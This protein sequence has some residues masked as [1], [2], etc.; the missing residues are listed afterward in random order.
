MKCITVVA[1]CVQY[2]FLNSL[3]LAHF[4]SPFHENIIF[5]AYISYKNL[6]FDKV[7]TFVLAYSSKHA[8]HVIKISLLLFVNFIIKHK[9]KNNHLTLI[10]MEA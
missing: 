10:L 2:S 6:A 9:E 7:A 3:I 8:E 5:L 4:L 1:I